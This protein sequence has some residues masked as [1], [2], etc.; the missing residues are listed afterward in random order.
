MADEPNGTEQPR[1]T[2]ERLDDA[3]RTRAGRRYPYATVGDWVLLADIPDKSKMAY[4]I[5]RAH[6]NQERGDEEVWPSLDTIAAL[7]RLNG[8]ERA[9]EAS[10]Y[11][12]HLVEMG[13][14]EIRPERYGPNRMYRR[15][16]YTVHE[17][18][19]ADYAGL[20]STEAWHAA[21]KQTAELV[22]ELAGA[23]A[24]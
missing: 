16:V 17:R 15:N 12:R 20:S 10:K 18:P 2:G 11:I 6:V 21:R 23:A 3:I 4:W 9:K 1:E 13:A 14:V 8:K 7:L 24:Q 22:D 19:P 5:L